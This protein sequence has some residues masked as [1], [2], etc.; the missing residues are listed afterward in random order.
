M[1]NYARR[2]SWLRR[3][4]SHINDDAVFDILDDCANRI[5]SKANSDESATLKYEISQTR[6]L[7]ELSA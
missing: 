6:A 2:A 3:V 4:A 1:A 7:I 5:S